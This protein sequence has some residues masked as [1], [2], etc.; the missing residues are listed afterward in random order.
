MTTYEFLER[1]RAVDASWFIML[2]LLLLFIGA[3]WQRGLA[4]VPFYMLLQANFIFMVIYI[5]LHLFIERFGTTM[6]RLKILTSLSLFIILLQVTIN[7]HFLGGAEGFIFYFLYLVPIVAIGLILF[8]IQYVLGGAL[9]SSAMLGAL[10]LL[11]NPSLV[12]YLNTIIGMPP[13][14]ASLVE[15]FAVT[16]YPVFGFELPPQTIFIIFLSYLFI[17]LVF[18]LLAHSTNPLLYRLITAER[19]R[20]EETIRDIAYHDSLT[21][22]PNRLFLVDRLNQ[23]LVRGRWKKGP[24]AIFCLDLDNFKHVND[25]YGR[26]RRD[27][28]LTAVA[29]RLIGC[30]RPGDIVSRHEGDEFIILFPDINM[31]EDVSKL[32]EKIFSAFSA[33]FIVKG[34]ELYSTPTIGISIYPDDGEDAEALLKDAEIALHRAKKNNFRFYAASM[35]EGVIEKFYIG[36][37]LHKAIENGEFLLYYQ[38]QVDT[39]TEAVIG[40]EALIRWQKPG[41]GVVQ[42]GKFISVAEDNGLIIPI[43]EYVLRTAAQQNKIWQ[44][45]GVKPMRIAINLSM[46]QFREK[47]LVEKVAMALKETD[48]DPKWLELELTESILME[49]VETVINKL[50]ALKSM[51]IRLVIDDFGTG[52]SS[53]EYLKKMPIDMLKIAHSFVRDIT[54]N[55]NNLAIARTIVSMGHS[56]NIEILAEGVET[57]EQLNL[58]KKIG[59]DKIQGFL[60]SKPLPSAEVEAFLKGGEALMEQIG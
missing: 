19:K 17:S 34:E 25:A 58:L 23:I 47:D 22:L 40:I 57:P 30:L 5:G 35:N 54:V 21:G 43:G 60:I 29:G 27:E 14:T 59:C 7:I 52:Y 4:D 42:P 10:L 2:P 46:L 51:G 13:W 32:I 28:L 6:F 37:R 3:L 18:A 36:N 31:R 9:I 41:T 48:L 33:P 24:A 11:E 50:H 16:S 49:D 45:N 44:D 26:K 8:R 53:L 1:K 39:K 55:P 12:W 56:L 20:S 38:P 15:R